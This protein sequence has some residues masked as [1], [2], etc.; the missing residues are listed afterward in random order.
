MSVPCS[1]DPLIHLHDE[2]L[3]EKKG[4]LGKLKPRKG[5]LRSQ[6]EREREYEERI[7]KEERSGCLAGEC[8]AAT[9]S[10]MHR[11]RRIAARAGPWH[12]VTIDDLAGGTPSL[13]GALSPTEIHTDRRTA[14][15][16]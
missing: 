13:V 3:P 8:E 2:A 1:R 12:E 11:G 7:N 14:E 16:I 9:M 6:R 5:E 4:I 10:D 15:R